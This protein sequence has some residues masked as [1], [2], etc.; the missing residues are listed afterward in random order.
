MDL[1][2]A[3]I[4]LTLTDF[5]CFCPVTEECIAHFLVTHLL[6][7][8]GREFWHFILFCSVTLRLG[9]QRLW[10][11]SF[12]VVLV[13]VWNR[14]KYLFAS[15]LWNFYILCRSDDFCEV[16]RYILAVILIQAQYF[17][18]LC[19]F[20]VWTIFRIKQ[21][22]SRRVF[23]YFMIRYYKLA[24]KSKNICFYLY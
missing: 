11:L 20:L 9:K 7:Q 10:L 24:Y 1:T 13:K 21:S 19:F 6:E 16:Y 17:E 4:I 23:A 2:L 12:Y 22:T 15:L 8:T 3:I 5:A 14:K 18:G